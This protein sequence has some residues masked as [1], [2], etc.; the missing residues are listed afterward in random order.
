MEPK[1]TKKADLE[2]SRPIFFQIGLLVVIAIVLYAFERTSKPELDK[3]LTKME[4]ALMEEEIIPITRQQ[5]VIQQPPPQQV[6]EDLEIVEDDEE[7]ENEIDVVDNL[8]DENTTFDIT[9][10]EQEE[11]AAVEEVFIIVEDMPLFNGKKAEVGFREYIAQN[12]DYPDIAAENGISGKV[13]VRFAV[14]KNGNVVDVVLLRGVHPALDKEALRVVR[15][16]P[17]WT[18]GKQRGR[19][20]KVQFVFPISFVLQQ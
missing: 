13:L 9:E 17:K 14:D 3:S 11:E 10:I 15:S 2:K 1:K 7:I 19:A 18:P 8:A 6:I 16:S 12:L 5:E 4:D 20:V